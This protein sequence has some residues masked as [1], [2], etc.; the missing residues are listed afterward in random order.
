MQRDKHIRLAEVV[1]AAMVIADSIYAYLDP[2]N[3]TKTCD[4]AFGGMLLQPCMFDFVTVFVF[5]VFQYAFEEL[6]L[7]VVSF[8]SFMVDFW[9]EVWSPSCYK[10]RKVGAKACLQRVC[11]CCRKGKGNDHSDRAS[12]AAHTD[13]PLRSRLGAIS[14]VGGSDR[15]DAQGSYQ[16]LSQGSRLSD[17]VETEAAVDVNVTGDIEMAQRRGQG[18]SVAP[19]LP[20]IATNV[21]VPASLFTLTGLLE[22]VFKEE[23]VK[24]WRKKKCLAVEKVDKDYHP[25]ELENDKSNQEE[26]DANAH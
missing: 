11:C 20:A 17:D 6:L 18:K 4:T 1:I 15:G 14:G 13:N 19:I 5:K 2:N 7:P 22:W 10:G 9:L 8:L 24:E 21:A 12:I 3:L 26:V 25:V 23:A 16:R